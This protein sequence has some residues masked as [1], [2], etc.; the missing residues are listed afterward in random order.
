MSEKV[1][2]SLVKEPSTHGPCVTLSAQPVKMFEV[3]VR[4]SDEKCGFAYSHIV[5][6]DHEIQVPET[7]LSVLV[8]RLNPGQVRAV[9]VHLE[10][11]VRE[12]RECRV[13]S[14]RELAI[15][16]GLSHQGIP[17]LFDLGYTQEEPLGYTR[18][19]PQ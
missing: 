18:L 1:V 6:I 19:P 14:L 3:Q 17:L 8:I 5:D 11:L 2:D 16:E 10:S 15:G 9:G 12:L 7:T 13:L 4:N